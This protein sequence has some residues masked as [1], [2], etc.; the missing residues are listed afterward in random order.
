MDKKSIEK[1]YEYPLILNK[2]KLN[3]KLDDPQKSSNLP[4]ISSINL[5]EKE[6]KNSLSP[7]EKYFDALVKPKHSFNESEVQV[8]SFCEGSIF[9][10]LPLYQVHKIFFIFINFILTKYLSLYQ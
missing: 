8:R 9:S 10:S 4:Q 6:K 1:N 7:N 3:G 5:K 2:Q